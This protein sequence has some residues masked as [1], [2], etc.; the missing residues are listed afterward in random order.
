MNEQ[1]IRYVSTTGPSLIYSIKQALSARSEIAIHYPTVNRR[2]HDLSDRGYLK[3]DGTRQ[4]KSGVEAA[5]YS[6]TIRGDFAALATSLNPKEQA[7]LLEIAGRQP[8]SPFMLLKQVAESDMTHVQEELLKEVRMGVRN[9][10]I[11]LEALD[12]DV[13]TSAF[14]TLI[15]GKLRKIL[16][17]GAREY[18]ERIRDIT[19]SVFHP[20]YHSS[21]DL[22]PNQA[23]ILGPPTQPMVE[24]KYDMPSN[25]AENAHVPIILG[26][27]RGSLAQL[28]R[29]SDSMS[30]LLKKRSTSWSLELIGYLRDM[31]N[32][33]DSSRVSPYE[34]VSFD[35][36]KLLLEINDVKNF[37]VHHTFVWDVTNKG[38]HPMDTLF[39]HITGDVPRTKFSDLNVEVRDANGDKLKLSKS[40]N[41]PLRKEFFAKLNVP[42][43]S[44]KTARNLR[45]S[46][47]WEEPDRSYFYSFPARCRKFSVKIVLPSKV[48]PYPHVYHIDSTNGQKSYA[49]T[50]PIVIKSSDNIEINWMTDDVVPLDVYR[51]DW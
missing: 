30:A 18:V 24:T 43:G 39:Y 50:Q 31:V 14:A 38:P 34:R 19:E 12:E 36:V 25:E 28:N 4:V 16:G 9:G 5:L 32:P 23:R 17:S 27:G 37:L 48:K 49:K 29:P 26:Q 8:G 45:M 40:V 6:T 51:F 1:I 33:R 13:I 41:T 10:Y 46:Y 42:I 11:N 2:V 47:D 20:S 44:K 3:K 22:D 35:E 21:P 15:A 7:K